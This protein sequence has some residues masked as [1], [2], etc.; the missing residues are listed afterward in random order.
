MAEAPLLEMIRQV[1]AEAAQAEAALG[2]KEKERLGI[3]GYK[4][5]F[6]DDA[7]GNCTRVLITSTEG[8]VARGFLCG[9]RTRRRR[10]A[11]CD[12]GWQTAL[13]DYPTGGPCPKCKGT[14]RRSG[15]PCHPCAATGYWMCNKPICSSCRAHRDPDEDYC[16][17]HRQM[18]GFAPLIRREACSWTNRASGL[19]RRDCLHAGCMELLAYGN[20]VLY[21]PRRRRAMCEGCGERYLQIAV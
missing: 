15:K 20:R 7:P 5:E 21:F 1:R 19:I 4:A 2:D 10:C 14:K 3:A 9:S 11:F 17:E 6:S 8:Q 12:S 18:A 16:P 13:C